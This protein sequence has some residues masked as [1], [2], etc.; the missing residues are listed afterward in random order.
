MAYIILFYKSNQIRYFEKKCTLILKYVMAMRIIFLE[1]LRSKI[2]IKHKRTNIRLK[3]R[4]TYS[5]TMRMNKILFCL[6]S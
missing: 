4:F 2:T 5:T 3:I 1:K 6:V